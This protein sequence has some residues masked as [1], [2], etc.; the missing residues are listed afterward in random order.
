MMHECRLHLAE[1]ELAVLASFQPCR[2]ALQAGRLKALDSENRPI[3]LCLHGWHDNAASFTP[4][5]EPLSQVFH[6]VAIDWPG[7]GLSAHRDPDNYYYFMDYVD[8]LAQVM[9]AIS[10]ESVMLMGHSLGALV[11]AAYAGAYPE[12]VSGLILIE[13]LV[14]L[15]ENAALAADR[16][17]SGIDSRMKRRQR[18]KPALKMDSFQA[19]LSVRCRVNGLTSEQLL[20]LVQRA[21]YQDGEGWSW[22]HDDKL[23]CD[24]LIRL[25]EAQSKALVASIECPVLSIVGDKG[26][27]HLKAPES[28]LSWF[29]SADQI[30]VPGGHHCHLESPQ[31]VCDQIL[32][33]TSKFKQL[34]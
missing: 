6:L 15:Y 29:A 23:R 32:L 28:G 18:Q 2:G 1:T 17:R 8:T 20:P 19:A 5:F 12:A 22:R 3:L 26:F 25:T 9:Q 34:V 11:A 30:V 31:K 27:A 13:G 4:L 16:L 33:L 24:S 14:P 21:I 10:G 7:H